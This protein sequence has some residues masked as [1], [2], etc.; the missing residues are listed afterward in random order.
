VIAEDAEVTV[1]ATRQRT[2]V[3]AELLRPAGPPLG[4]QRGQCVLAAAPRLSSRPAPTR[5][6]TRR[7]ATA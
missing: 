5:S 1:T 7:T 2:P 6:R 4:Y 3:T